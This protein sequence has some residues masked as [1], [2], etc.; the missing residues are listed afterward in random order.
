[1][2]T[3][4]AVISEL[5]VEGVAQVACSVLLNQT[6]SIL[7]VA[8]ELVHHLSLGKTAV[9][10]T[11]RNSEL[12]TLCPT[13]VLLVRTECYVSTNTSVI[14]VSPRLI[15]NQ[16]TQ[17]VVVSSYRTTVL[18]IVE[19][20]VTK[21]IIDSVTLSILLIQRI[22]R[23]RELSCVPRV[24]CRCIAVLVVRR[25]GVRKVCIQTSL[26]PVSYLRVNISTSAVTLET[27]SLQDTILV[28]ITQRNHVVCSVGTT[29][30]RNVVL[31]TES[32]IYIQRI[33]PVLVPS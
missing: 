15:V 4:L 21:A 5:L 10:S 31:M 3:E 14:A 29:V 6:T 22:E 2:V 12:K 19:L 20:W 27:S 16:S 30:N 17:R 7:L 23:V 25:L 32:T 24:R 9:V 11:E 26:E 13:E 18:T 8:M 33:H 28:Y 1:M